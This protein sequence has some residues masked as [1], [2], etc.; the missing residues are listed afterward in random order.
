MSG[1][2]R[3]PGVGTRPVGL[4]RSLVPARFVTVLR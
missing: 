4:E 1:L 3:P 2:S